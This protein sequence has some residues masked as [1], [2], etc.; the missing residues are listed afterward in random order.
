VDK[1]ISR[2]YKRTSNRHESTAPPT[3]KDFLG[4]EDLYT[5]IQ[6]QF[7]GGEDLMSD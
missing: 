2:G 4:I 7:E 6:L 3:G 5:I 1:F